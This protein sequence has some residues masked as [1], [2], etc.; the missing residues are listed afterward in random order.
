MFRSNTVYTA[1]NKGADQPA[2]MRRLICTFVVTGS[3]Q[4]FPFFSSIDL[5]ILKAT[6]W[7]MKHK[8]TLDLTLFRALIARKCVLFVCY[9]RLRPSKQ[10]V[11]SCLDKLMY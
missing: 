4:K 6:L 2:Q 8:T 11:S 1:V 3:I 5:I 7:F 9:D 10:F